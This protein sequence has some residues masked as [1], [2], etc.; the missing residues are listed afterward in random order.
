MRETRM[1]G[2]ETDGQFESIA[3]ADEGGDHH[4]NGVAGGWHYGIE[5]TLAFNVQLKALGAYQTG[6]DGYCFSG[7]NKWNHADT[8]QVR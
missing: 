7:A 3:C 8:D 1:G 2:L 6:A 4:H 5:A